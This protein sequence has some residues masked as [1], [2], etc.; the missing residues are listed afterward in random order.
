MMYVVVVYRAPSGNSE[1]SV[2][3]LDNILNF[4]YKPRTGF[5]I[6]GYI[7]TDCLAGSYHKCLDSPLIL[8]NLMST[9]NFPTRT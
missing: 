2:D 8:F 4:L 3:G 6:C 7:N 5:V 9:L 1:H